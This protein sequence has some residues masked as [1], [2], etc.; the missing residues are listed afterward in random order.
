MQ[1]F[2]EQGGAN[3]SVFFVIFF[4]FAAPLY[5]CE[6][7]SSTNVSPTSPFR[8]SVVRIELIGKEINFIQDGGKFKDKRRSINMVRDQYLSFLTTL[9]S[10]HPLPLNQEFKTVST[11]LN[12][13]MIEA[14][15]EAKPILYP[16]QT[17]CS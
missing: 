6:M 14:D 10:H 15:T 17:G 16:R 1:R 2:T 9:I 12:Q 11:I 4:Q 13:R 3:C 8:L 7:V 5:R